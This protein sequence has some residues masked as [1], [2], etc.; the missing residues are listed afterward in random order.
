LALAARK[1]YAALSDQGV[2][3]FRAAFDEF[4]DLRLSC[5]LPYPF[6][7]NSFGCSPKAMFSATVVSAKKILCGTWA[8]VRCQAR[9]LSP[10]RGRA[11]PKQ[12]KQGRIT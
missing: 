10:D 11:D 2:I 5:S 4:S 6:H 8:M 12:E 3:T 9:S 7:I 1:T